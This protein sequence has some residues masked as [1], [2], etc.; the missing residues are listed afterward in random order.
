MRRRE[1]T[2]DLRPRTRRDEL[3]GGNRSDPAPRPLSLATL[4]GRNLYVGTILLTLCVTSALAVHCWSEYR[5]RLNEVR[6]DVL[7]ETKEDVVNI[8]DQAVA[9]IEYD[10]RR[11]AKQGKTTAEIQQKVKDRLHSISFDDGN[12]YLFVTTFDGI[13]LVNRTRPTLIDRNVLEV[14]DPNGVTLV[15][16]LIEAAKQ[17]EGGFV[18]YIWNKPNGATGV[19]KI[20]YARGI[21]DWQWMVGAG[22]Y[23]DHVDAAVA[24]MAARVRRSFLTEMAIIV[25]F[26]AGR[27]G[28][29]NAFAAPSGGNHSRGAWPIDRRVAGQDRNGQDVGPGVDTRSRSSPK[30]P[31]R[32]P[33]PFSSWRSPKSVSPT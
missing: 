19:R 6:R 18:S 27:P 5:S 26:A 1:S 16:E 14:T 11:L 3:D 4:V 32:P 9:Q 13:E 15:R 33:R 28:N 23:L 31:I 25:G 17:P 8:V 29:H 21:Q 24:K 2:G 22:L 7:E 20:S 10:R 12:G 30:S